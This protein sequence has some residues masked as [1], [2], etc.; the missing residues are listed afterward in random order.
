MAN[1]QKLK[2]IIDLVMSI[3]LLL[4]LLFQI[5]DQQAHEYLGIMMLVLFLGHNVLNRKWYR[6]LFNNDA[7]SWL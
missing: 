5:T 7:R 4:L 2:I 6:H 3:T 1:K